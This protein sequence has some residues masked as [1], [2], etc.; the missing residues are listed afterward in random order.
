MQLQIGLQGQWAEV[1][2]AEDSVGADS[3]ERVLEW[4]QVKDGEEHF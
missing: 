1:T 3:P 4:L 2:Q